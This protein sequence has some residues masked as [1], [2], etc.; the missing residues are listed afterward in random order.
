MNSRFLAAMA[1]IACLA[2]SYVNAQEPVWDGNKVELVSER[3]SDGVYAYYPKDAKALEKDGKPVATSGGFIVGKNKVLM[4]E[5]M[6]N[7]RLYKQAEKLIGK[8]T[9]LPISF[10]V[11]TS[12]HGDH[13]FGNMYLPSATSIIQHQNTSQYISK[14]L[15]DDKAF[16]IKNFGAGRGIE[17][18][19]ARTGNILVPTGGRFTLDL[20][21]KQVDIIDFG[22]AQTGGDLFVWE[23]QS[24]TLWTGNPVIA[25]K[26]ALPWLLDGHLVETLST[27][28]KVYAFLPP[29]AKIVPGNGSLIT[30]EDIKWHIDYLETIKTQVKVAIDKG[31]SLEE[32]VKTVTMPEFSGYAL[33]GWV[34]PGLNVPAAFKD[35][36]GK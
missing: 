19:Q 26:P 5:T 24:K 23:P 6:L 2:S 31:L 17:P 27:L 16:M 30:R 8:V 14:H 33:F 29:D 34:H 11:N 3:L 4:I 9:N 18:I 28:K 7:Q 21:G 36:S 12:V 20:G 35:L 1:L 15:E 32:T 10:A 25:V 22:F 13:S